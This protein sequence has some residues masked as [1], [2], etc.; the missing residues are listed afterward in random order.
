MKFRPIVFSLVFLLFNSTY[1]N[2]LNLEKNSVSLKDF[3][4]LKI[5]LFIQQNIGNMFRGGGITN[6]KYQSIDY[7][8]KID[9]N[10]NILIKMKAVMD[11]KRY[12]AKKY[13]PKLKDCNQIRNKIFTNNYGYSFFTQKKNYLVSEQSLSSAINENILNISSVDDNFKLKIIEKMGIQIE[14]LHPLANKSI[15]CSGKLT[16]VDLK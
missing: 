8:L 9:T 3:L 13:Y 6:I 4:F 1:A 11:K 10:N 16:D 2:A 14:I 7:D 15:S 5:D 12:N